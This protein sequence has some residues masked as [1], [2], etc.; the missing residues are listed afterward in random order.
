MAKKNRRGPGRPK[1]G[2]INLAEERA[3][4]ASRIKANAERLGTINFEETEEGLQTM[5]SEE[6]L[7]KCTHAELKELRRMAERLWDK[8]EIEKQYDEE[9]EWSYGMKREPTP[10]SEE[11]DRQHEFL[12]PRRKNAKK[13]KSILN[14]TDKQKLEKGMSLEPIQDEL[15]VEATEAE[16]QSQ[17]MEQATTERADEGQFLKGRRITGRKKVDPEAQRKK[18][19]WN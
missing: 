18:S 5:L 14:L 6:K 7:K 10:Q 9:Q 13:V 12:K 16:V 19:F 8:F 15:N 1:K 4:V 2:C 3:K 11:W 17:L